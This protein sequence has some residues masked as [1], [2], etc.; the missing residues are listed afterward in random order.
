MAGTMYYVKHFFGWLGILLNIGC[1]LIV[2]WLVWTMHQPNGGDA[3]VAILF[4][5]P[6]LLG[7]MLVVTAVS[8][9]CF[10]S[11]GRAARKL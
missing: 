8:V 6:I 4:V 7:I 3:F 5:G 9:L 10:G 11:L 1:L 2:A